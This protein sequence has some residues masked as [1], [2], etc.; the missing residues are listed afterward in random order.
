MPSIFAADLDGGGQ[1]RPAKEAAVPLFN[2][3]L[4]VPLA[5]PDAVE[6]ER[7]YPGNN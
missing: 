1:A 2:G 7:I 5:A 6:V 3:L 4:A